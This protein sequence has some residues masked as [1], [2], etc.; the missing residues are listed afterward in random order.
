MD[1]VKAIKRNVSQGDTMISI[2]N[3]T[4]SLQRHAR[5]KL[6]RQVLFTST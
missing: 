6:W 3:H 4:E 2:D 1:C 5:V